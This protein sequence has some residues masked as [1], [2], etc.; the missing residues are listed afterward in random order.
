MCIGLCIKL[1]A[2]PLCALA[3]ASI[4]GLEGLEVEVAIMESGMPPMVS[5]GALAI[6]AN[7][8]PTLTAALV[9]AGIVLSFLTLPVIFHLL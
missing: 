9:G 4:V 7:L 6:L 5:A 3:I 8:S 1:G 2:A